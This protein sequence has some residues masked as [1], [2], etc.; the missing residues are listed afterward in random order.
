MAVTM[1]ASMVGEAQLDQT[2]PQQVIVTGGQTEMNARR[3]STAG[4]ITIGRKRIEES[5]VEKVADL[6]AREPGLPSTLGA[7]GS[8]T[9][10]QFL[11]DGLPPAKNQNLADM[12]L[13]LVEKIEIIKTTVAEF[14]PYGIAG[15]INIITRKIIAEQKK[16]DLRVAYNT[17]AG[18]P[19]FNLS[20]SLSRGKEE[21]VL[22][23]NMQLSSSYKTQE[24][25]GSLSQTSSSSG[26]GIAQ[27]LQGQASTSNRFVT[28]AASGNMI[29]RP[30][31]RHQ[32]IFSPAINT[33]TSVWANSNIRQWDDGSSLEMNEHF[34]GN[35]EQ[36]SLPLSWTI[37]L[38]EQSQLMLFTR[39]NRDRGHMETVWDEYRS[40]LGN[41]LRRNAAD[42]TGNSATFKLDYKTVLADVH[43]IKTGM[44]LTRSSDSV[45]EKHWLNGNPDL[46][47]DEF[48]APYSLVETKLRWFWQDDWRLDDSLSLNLGISGEQ[49]TLD[50]QERHYQPHA[51]YRVLSPS[52]HVLKKLNADGTQR[53]RFS[54]ARS[55]N[56]PR[57]GDLMQRPFINA[58]APCLANGVCIANG[59]ETADS[60]GNPDLQPERSLGLNITYEYDLAANSLLSLGLYTRDI[61][62]KRGSEIRLENVA[63]SNQARY[64]Y[65]P[66]NFG[67][68]S[69][70]GID[71]ELQLAL[72]DL[73]VQAPDASLRAGLGLARSRVNIRSGLD[74]LTDCQTPWN[75]KLGASYTARVW[76]LKLDIDASWAPGN[77][78]RINAQQRSFSPRQFNLNAGAVWKF[79]PDTSLT[80]NLGNILADSRTSVIEYANVDGVV[81]Q[82]SLDKSHTR[83]SMRLNFKL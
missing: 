69:V 62:K 35:T 61:D 22:S 49:T 25:N 75:A 37:R 6:L 52:M 19:G 9:Y 16:T 53:M 2:I 81:R 38:H 55:F 76:P 57:S 54:L 21:D 83:L 78:V 80:I 36:L 66:V 43:E 32:L 51:F 24:S 70:Q 23:M 42:S 27:Q 28:L 34:H 79:N 73:S 77:W 46:A 59:L 82:Q 14:G 71:M 47:L 30:A 39:V 72:R 63:W 11:I 7:L 33:S 44:H 4:K 15:T 12:D 50:L 5:G 67:D 8:P 48:N 1:A 64:V 58:L 31:Q 29:W 45:D 20:S 10:T 13:Q 74:M 17:S 68:A 3:D 56:A 41:S 65:R 26:S 60:S 40:S 18:Q